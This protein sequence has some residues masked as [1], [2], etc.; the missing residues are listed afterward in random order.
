MEAN[1]DNLMQFDDVSEF[2]SETRAQFAQTALKIQNG[3]RLDPEE[4][5]LFAEQAA[6]L[7]TEALMALGLGE[8]DAADVVCDWFFTPEGEPRDVG[9][10]VRVDPDTLEILRLSI[11]KIGDD[12]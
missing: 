9:L 11:Q 2:L 7:M 10:T 5:G 4:E 6:I 3:L 8:E 12:Q 1:L